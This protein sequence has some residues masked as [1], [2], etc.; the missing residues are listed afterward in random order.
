MAS[1]RG[2]TLIELLVVV[3]IIGVLAAAFLPSLDT[4][5]DAADSAA[6]R[7]NMGWHYANVQHYMT[8]HNELPRGDGPRWVLDPWVRGVIDHNLEN[9]ERFFAPGR[10]G[11]DYQ[12]LRVMV[13]KDPHSIWQ[14]PNDITSLDTDWAG[15]SAA[16]VAGMRRPGPSTPILATDNEG[17]QPTYADGHINVLLGGG[18][19]RTLRIDPDFLDHGHSV[20]TAETQPVVV[21]PASPH[22]LLVQMSPN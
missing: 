4:G 11:G 5:R 15:P 17:R 13:R 2:F 22:P 7:A 10:P 19:I 6:E 3:A 9:F 20:A 14:Q 21:G 1:S 18:A 12:A 16:S 8:A